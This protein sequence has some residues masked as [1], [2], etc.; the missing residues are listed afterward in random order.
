MKEDAE[1]IAENL[2]EEIRGCSVLVLWLDCDEEG[3]NIAQEVVDVCRSAA[4]RD[5][6]VYRARFSAVTA[7]DIDRALR[8]LGPINENVVAAVDTRTE[9]DL[10]L[11]AV[12]TRFQ[13]GACVPCLRA[14]AREE[15]THSLTH[16]GSLT[17]SLCSVTACVPCPRL[18]RDFC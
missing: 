6:R 13:S 12:F 10:R 4:R 11:G 16:V 2:K 1:Q 18:A 7:R 17:R 5:L 8:Q 3:E 14:C 9:I 15:L